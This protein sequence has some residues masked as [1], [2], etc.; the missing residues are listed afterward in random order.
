MY[1]ILWQAGKFITG[2]NSAN[3]AG[4]QGWCWLLEVG[5]HKENRLL[6]LGNIQLNSETQGA[7]PWENVEKNLPIS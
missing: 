5:D 2:S 7:K 3:L 6:F 1:E 4:L